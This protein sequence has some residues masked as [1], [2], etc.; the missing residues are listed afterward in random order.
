MSEGG[1]LAAGSAWSAGA[2]ARIPWAVAIAAALI[3]AELAAMLTVGGGR[4]S[5]T[6]DDAYIHLAVSEELARGGYGV[7]A[8]EFAAP[9][10]SIL[11]PLLLAPFAA[12]EW[13][14][15]VPLALNVGFA[16]A[17]VAL[18]R[19]IVGL[20]LE[21]R[22]RSAVRDGLA[23]ILFL[24]GGL[25]PLVFTGME[26]VLQVGLTLA[27][28]HGMLLA[29]RDGRPPHWLWPA[30]ALAP[31]VRYESLALT[32][33]LAVVLWREGHRRPAALALAAA[34]AGLAAFSAI[35]LRHGLPPLPSSVLSKAA[36]L[37]PGGSIMAEF[38]RRAV[39]QIWEGEGVAL[40][41]VVGA[42]MA[43]AASSP[44]HRAIALALAAATLLH[45]A[46]G[47]TR[48]SFG[49]YEAYI[50]IANLAFLAMILGPR[51]G[52]L[53]EA[54]GAALALLLAALVLTPL[55]PR[56]LYRI[57]ATPLAGDNIAAQQREMARFAAAFVR[58]PVAVND[59][60]WV[61]YRNEQYVLDLWG[62]GS[63][64]ARRK[65]IRGEPG[66]A[67]ELLRRHDVVLMMIYDDWLREA[68]P[69][70]WVPIGRLTLTRARISPARHEVAFHAR[71]D[72]AAARRDQARLFARGLPAGSEFAFDWPAPRSGSGP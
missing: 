47:L 63:E 24:G 61:S 7:N 26:H 39:F 66:W 22:P 3:A 42:L 37:E 51:L 49:R 43:A 50:L 53:A 9:A 6:L 8:G 20:A 52:A 16:L 34:G 32:L 27:V 59:L 64:E 4:F 5:Y 46:F 10:S 72:R 36:L 65:R 31:L 40:L 18:V 35:L 14:R 70:D 44:R 29:Q 1:A 21:E 15:F 58:G 60:G 71:P 56:A 62:L 2:G 68:V 45:L 23:L 69:P 13:H 25:L 12:F 33:P 19:R 48:T 55:W 41:A 28:L 38:A 67:E 11:W 54:R 17:S 30:L 57:A